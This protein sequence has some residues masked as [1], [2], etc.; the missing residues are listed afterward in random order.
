LANNL[1][2]GIH[3]AGISEV[4]AMAQSWGLN[5]Q[6]TL[7]VMQASSGQSWIGQDRMQRALQNDFEPRAHTTLLAKDTR[8]ALDACQAMSVKMPALGVLATEQFARACQNG[9]A[10]LDDASLFLQAGGKPVAE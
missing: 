8:L 6:T 4:L 1:L 3:L 10:H 9:F 2:A 5:A 7:A